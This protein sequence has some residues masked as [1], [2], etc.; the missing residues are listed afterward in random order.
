M[1]TTKKQVNRNRRKTRIRA[2]VSGTAEVPR[3]SIYKSLNFNYAQLIDDKKGITLA[4]A[5]DIKEKKGKKEERAKNIGLKIAELAK[6]KKIS[7]C[8]FDRNGFKYHGRVKAMAEGAR[9][10][11]LKF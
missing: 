6:E 4:S 2:I 9:E 3:L 11:G 5:S 10:G 8:V 7:K 1:K